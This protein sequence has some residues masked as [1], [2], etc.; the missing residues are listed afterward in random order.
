MLYILGN[1]NLGKT[2]ATGE[3]VLSNGVEVLGQGYFDEAAASRKTAEIAK[4]FR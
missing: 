2:D 3:S 4:A 1:G